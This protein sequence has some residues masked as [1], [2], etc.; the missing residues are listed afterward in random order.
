MGVER[1]KYNIVYVDPSV[2]VKRGPDLEQQ[3]AKQSRYHI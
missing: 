2:E 3:W 1:G